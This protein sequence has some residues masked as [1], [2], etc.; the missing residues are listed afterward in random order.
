MEAWVSEGATGQSYKAER[1]EGEQKKQLFYVKLL[2]RE[3]SEKRGF[4]ELFMQECQALEQ[5]EGPGIWPL[6]KFGVMKWKHWLAYDWHSGK[7]FKIENDAEENESREEEF[8]YIYSLEDDLKLHPQKWAEKDLLA[9]MITL[10]RALYQTHSN[11]FLHGNL[12]PSNILISRPEDGQLEAWITEFG[13]YR[14]VTMASETTSGDESDDTAAT[15]LQAQESQNRSADFRP[16][17]QGWGQG[18]DEK[19]D[20]FGLGVVVKEIMKKMEP[21]CDLSEWKAWS[22]KAT[23]DDSFESVA[24]S[25]D[26]L[27]GVGDISQYGVKIEDASEISSEETE[28]IRKKR[29]QEWAFEEKTGDLRFRRNM[30][31]LV[32]GLFV[33]AYLIKS[34]YLFFSPA[35]WT[36]YSLDGV[37]DSYQLAA[38]IWSGQAWGI[39][40]GAYDDEGDGGQDVVGEWEKEDGLFKLDFRKFKTPE[41][42]GES[43]KLWQF[44]GK[45]ATSPD[46]Y[47]IWS[48][49][50]SYD[51]SRDAL[52]LIK[53]TDGETTYK[54]GKEGDRS[55]RLYPERRFIDRSSDVKPAELM[56]ARTGESGISWELFLGLGFL[57]SCSMYF[58]SLNRLILAGP[59]SFDVA[60]E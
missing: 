21:T 26:A 28:R 15:T 48:D 1:T 24:Y 36:E 8:E 18:V 7:A 4:E 39:L 44:I 25:M 31:G 23:S 27:P 13:L 54:P 41:D 2:P 3:I 14:L 9:L 22:E 60:K 37:L 45:G 30:T 11:G 12:K 5:I 58:R 38:G 50:L 52:L 55:P 47:F 16:A 57:L 34:V 53:R 59:E 46:D 6:R 10:H 32:G 19:W 43:K 33:L 35:P 49:Y 40:P 20:L 42:N 29:E 56:F 51:R 17:N